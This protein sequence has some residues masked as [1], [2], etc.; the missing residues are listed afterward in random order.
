LSKFAPL[1]SS[2]V[3]ALGEIVPNT[4]FTQSIPLV[5][6][7]S[8]DAGAYPLK[9]SFVYEDGSGRQFVDEQVITLLVYN[10]PQV[11]ASFSEPVPDMMLGEFRP[12]PIQITN[13]GKKL[14]VL[15]D[16]TVSASSGLLNKNTSTVG[17]VDTGG[18]FTMDV[19]YTADTPGPVTVTIQIKYTDDFQQDGLIEKTLTLNVIDMPTPSPDDGGDG[20]N[21]GEVP[22][23]P[24]EETLIDKILKALL[25]FFGFS[26]G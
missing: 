25:G 10:L 24:T 3:Y 23:P 2:N 6:N 15:G 1:G 20:T 4:T 8:T 26:G 21:G 12:L 9:I 7:V 16:I 11:S 13:I 22:L 19:E 17:T 18:Y 5:V 14:T